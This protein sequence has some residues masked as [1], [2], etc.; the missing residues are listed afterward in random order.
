MTKRGK[1]FAKGQAV[2]KKG[3]F[4]WATSKGSPELLEYTDAFI[5]YMKATGKLKELQIK[6]FGQSFDN[7]PDLHV[8]TQKDYVLLSEYK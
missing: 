4:A 5:K 7:L 2:S 6:W 8:I 1:I 3:Y